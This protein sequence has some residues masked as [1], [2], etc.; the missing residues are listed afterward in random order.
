MDGLATGRIVHFNPEGSRSDYNCRAAVVTHVWSP[1]GMVNLYVFSDG[2]TTSSGPVQTSIP[3]GEGARN[4]H[5]PERAPGTAA[6]AV[7]KIVDAI[8]DL[9]DAEDREVSEDQE[10]AVDRHEWAQASSE[11]FGD[12]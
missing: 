10:D 7:A 11:R 4:W 8:A 3:F 6:E 1:E 5:W 9:D 12:G 2:V